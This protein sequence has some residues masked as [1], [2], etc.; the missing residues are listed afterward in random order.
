MKKLKTF[1]G[2]ERSQNYAA[3]SCPQATRTDEAGV[4]A[5]GNQHV[6]K[7]PTCSPPS[8]L[9]QGA[10]EVEKVSGHRRTGQR[11]VLWA[12]EVALGEEGSYTESISSW[13]PELALSSFFFS[14]IYVC[15]YRLLSW[16]VL[17]FPMGRSKGE[18]AEGTCSH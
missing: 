16:R 8:L 14:G 3:W 11:C 6:P 4:G 5:A 10:H 13:M 1:A 12:F 17:A 18:R 15:S 2:R 7:R 9:H